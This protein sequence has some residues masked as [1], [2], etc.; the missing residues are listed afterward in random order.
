MGSPK[1]RLIFTVLL[2]VLCGGPWL[3]ASYVSSNSE[4]RAPAS[5]KPATTSG[6]AVPS[7]KPNGSQARDGSGDIWRD[8]E[9]TAIPRRGMARWVEPQ[10]YRTLALDVPALKARLAAAPVEGSVRTQASP[11]TISLPLP[12]RGFGAFRIVESSIMEPELARKFPDIKTYLGQGV[13]DPAATVRFDWTPQ[14][15]HAQVLTPRGNYYIDPYQRGDQGHYI[16]YFRRDYRNVTKQLLCGV[17]DRADADHLDTAAVTPLN[18][19]GAT[20]RTYRLACA[21]TGEYT[22]TYGGTVTGGLGGIVTTINRCNGIYERDLAIRFVLVANNDL[23]VYTN[24]ASDPYSNNDGVAMLGQNQTNLDNVIGNANYDIGHVFSTGGGGVAG[25]GVVCTTGQ[26]ARGVTGLSTPTGDIYDVDY[27]AHEIGH[28]YGARHPFNGNQGACSG[29]RSAVAAYEVGSGNTIMAYAGICAA[30][31]LQPNSDDYFHTISFQEIFNYTNSGGGS[32]CPVATATGNTPPT[33]TPLTGF[34]IPRQTPFTLTVA[35]SDPDGD[36]LTYC[37]EQFDLGPAQSAARPFSD[38]GSSPI[39]R[40][41][42][43]VTSPSRTFPSLRYILNNQN[44]PNNATGVP[45]ETLPNTNR[46]LT[47]RVTARDNRAGGGGVR[48]ATVG[49]TVTTAAGPFTVTAPNTAVTWAAGSSQ[50]VTWNVNGTDVAPVNATN[51]NI[52]L[53]VDGGNTYP[54]TLA[55]NVPNNGTAS[56]T[57]P[58][59]TQA[60]A[61]ARVRVE[62]VLPSGSG[63]FFD[64]SDVGFS[65]TNGPTAAPTLT[66]GGPIVTRQGSPTTAPVTVATIAGGTAPYTFTLDQE[67]PTPDLTVAGFISGNIITATATA[68]CNLVAPNPP[69]V[70]SY[71]VRVTVT[72][73]VGRVVSGNFNVN[74]SN[75]AIPTLGAF[76]NQTVPVG[77][78]VDVSPSQGPADANNNLAGLTVSPTTLPGGGTVSVN[79]TT[80]VVTVSTVGTTTPGSYVIEVRTADTCGATDIERFTV[81]VQPS[82]ANLALGT[83]TITTGDGQI[84]PNECNA[85]SI[86]LINDGVLDA[87]AISATLSTTTSGVTVT[88]ATSAYPNLLAGGGAGVNTTPFQVSTTGSIACGTT[89]NFTLTVTYSGGPSPATFNFTLPVGQDVNNYQFTST[90]TGA[91]IPPGGTFVPGSAADDV[92][93]TT[94]TPFAFLVYGTPVAA[95]QTITVSTNGNVQFVA[96]GGSTSLTNVSLPAAVFPNVPVVCPY[97]DDLILTTTGGGIYTNTVGTAPN[98]QFIIEWRGRRFG[99][100]GGPTQNLNFAVV[101]N[102]G[103]SQFQFRYVQTGIGATA[104]G[105]SATVGVQAGNTAMSNFTQFSF[106][107]SVI[108][109]GL[110]L[111]AALGQ[112]TPGSGP[113]GTCLPGVINSQV[114]LVIT[115]SVLEAPTCGAQGYANDFVMSGT[116]TNVSA[117][118]LSNLAFEVVELQAA[119]GP[120]PTVPFR[121]I[122]ADGATCASGGLV[123][124]IQTP[125]VTTLAPG[126]STT[127]TFRVALPSVRRFRFFVNV[128]GCTGGG[129]VTGRESRGLAVA[130]IEV[131]TDVPPVRRWGGS[132]PGDGLATKRR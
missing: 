62:A 102:E 130:P 110:Q 108:T 87:T 7:S 56:V 14:G 50:T 78:S 106:N 47:F 43:P 128:L 4:R 45:G 70:R 120:A 97:W 27:V 60:T 68:S 121:L 66:L 82:Q 72:D 26:K 42:D 75:N 74:V 107:Q 111:A 24:A 19:S 12:D 67:S 79:Q 65:I 104:N 39:F 49:V 129:S 91:V 52:L 46:T 20:L 94:T 77:A 17:T 32:G 83:R 127:V 85:L 18:P 99:D 2:A 38:N 125:S 3:A 100:G 44:D 95:G 11:V 109:P 21:A 31:N 28:Q 9:E 8:T 48:H 105:A 10:S 29:N 114:S 54:V 41:F 73:A 40:S 98:R 35:A 57:V 25:L 88:Q 124:A 89:I 116:L 118:P 101:F 112:C 63:T 59:S 93:V 33:I 61:Q 5:A 117:T 30:D 131:K 13:D 86:Q 53:S 103:S 76:S 123:G 64:V 37:W 81:T 34:T 58:S 6:A 23:I 92:V 55:S 132:S 69:S 115:G 80:G 71:P 22:A 122:S 126:A 1:R 15:F 90:P 51:V 84:D 119:N 113:C 16:A 36:P 96:S